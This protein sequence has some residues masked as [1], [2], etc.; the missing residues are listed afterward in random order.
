MAN[1]CGSCGKKAIPLAILGSEVTIF[2]ISEDNKR[3]ALE[4][5]DAA[6]VKIDFVVGDILNI[7]MKKYGDSFDVVFM[8]GSPQSIIF[9]VMFLKVRWLMHDFS[10]MKFGN[11]CLYAVIE[12]TRSVK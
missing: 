7:D 5:A 3:Y 11:R 4:V 9:Q 1:I 12:N 2:D 8:E 10:L 6:N